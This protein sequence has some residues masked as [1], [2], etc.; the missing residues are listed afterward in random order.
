MRLLEKKCR[1]IAGMPL[2]QK[3]IRAATA[4]ATAEAATYTTAAAMAA[5]MA[6][7]TIANIS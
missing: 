2:K 1:Q 3:Q 7:A 6:A 5:A 4:A